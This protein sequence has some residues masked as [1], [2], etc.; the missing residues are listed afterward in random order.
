MRQGQTAL[1][2]AFIAALNFYFQPAVP[3]AS[4]LAKT[5]PIP[6][7]SRNT[8]QQASSMGC[9]SLVRGSF[10]PDFGAESEEQT[11]SQWTQEHRMK[12]AIAILPDPIHTR[13]ALEFDRLVEGIQE[14]AVESNY[15]FERADL[16]PWPATPT[17]A[18]RSGVEIS[19]TTTDI[20]DQ[21]KFEVAGQN[22]RSSCPG[23]LSFRGRDSQSETH[24]TI[25]LVGEKPTEGVDAPEFLN[26]LQIASDSTPQGDIIGI[27]GPNFS[28]SYASLDRL[29]TASNKAPTCD[30][31]HPNQ[32]FFVMKQFFFVV[33]SSS[34]MSGKEIN[35]FR[36]LN[37]CRASLISFVDT[38][39][40]QEFEIKK[41]LTTAGVKSKKIAELSEDETAFGSSDSK[42]DSKLDF[43]RIYFP[44]GIVTLRSAYQ[45]ASL[46]STTERNHAP[47]TTLKPD[48]GTEGEDGDT[49]HTYATRHAP[50]SQEAVLQEIVRTLREHGI[51]FVI[52]R[53]TDINDTLFLAGRLRDN[54]PSARII[55]LGA[56]LLERRD[57]DDNTLR[58]TLSVSNYPPLQGWVDH[59]SNH[60]KH[61]IFSDFT[62]EG[63]FN[64]AVEL[65]KEMENPADIVRK[66]SGPDYL[67]P[68]PYAGFM[69]PPLD[70]KQVDGNILRPRLWINVVGR[71]GYWPLTILPMGDLANFLTQEGESECK[72][73]AAGQ[74]VPV[75]C[76]PPAVYNSSD[77]KPD[78]STVK[79]PARKRAGM[80][81]DSI[82]NLIVILVLSIVSF[83]FIYSTWWGDISNTGFVPDQYLGPMS[84]HRRS[85]LFVF[86]TA[87]L[88]IVWS[89][90]L[91]NWIAGFPCIVI[92]AATFLNSY[93]LHGKPIL[94]SVVWMIGTTAAWIVLYQTL[95]PEDPVSHFL[96]VY[97]SNRFASGLSPNLPLLLICGAILW[98]TWY[99]LKTGSWFGVRRP[100]LPRRDA[101]W[102]LPTHERFGNAGS[103]RT[104]L[105]TRNFAVICFLFSAA[106]WVQPL[107]LHSLE[108]KG[109]DTLYNIAACFALI[110]LLNCLYAAWEY[111]RRCRDLLMALNR[112]PLRYSFMEIRGF[113]WQRVWSLSGAD[114]AFVYRPMSRARQALDRLYRGLDPRT[115]AYL[116]SANDSLLKEVAELT[117]QLDP[118]RKVIREAGIH[119]EIDPRPTENGPV[120]AL[121]LAVKAITTKILDKARARMSFNDACSRHMESFQRL[122]STLA[123]LVY[124]SVLENYWQSDPRWVTRDPKKNTGNE[125]QVDR[126]SAIAGPS[127]PQTVQWAEEFVALVYISFIIRVLIRIR[128]LVM[129]AV[130]IYVFLLLAVTLYPFEPKVT[131]HAF[132][133]SIFLAM[134]AVA[135]TIYAQ[136]HRDDILSYLTNTNPGELGGDY[137]WRMVSFAGVPLFTLLSAQIPQLNRVLFFWIKPLLDGIGRS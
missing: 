53:A 3:E 101:I 8:S 36:S 135:G 126:S 56:D 95:R 115:Q 72:I 45:E 35:G 50:L 58:G 111:W 124:N 92:A 52:I 97:R 85:M 83:V 79:D 103:A 18:D 129:T 59:S 74:E 105:F 94:K 110:L 1:L 120:S 132:F 112:T 16:M 41:F 137:W 128:W 62:Q 6:I 88:L 75:A 19:M 31:V 61:R 107:R 78:K 38:V 4:V 24:L 106:L 49:V 87:V 136:M 93:Y 39:A 33:R 64:A 42:S 127:V 12:F 80:D 121:R 91:P 48:L 113:E 86:A 2:L 15:N 71:D 51:A 40:Y 26:A 98:W 30:S 5:N 47:R 109:F 119:P 89:L 22:E 66:P 117:V 130:G 73:R 76:G 134:L 20:P 11:F 123:T 10:R 25:L 108:G 28:G 60:E 34:T 27:L 81:E 63:E 96:F 84:D 43:V 125:N 133:V 122:L 14:A 104:L 114:S 82:L 17:T 99:Q 29:I 7:Q 46:V 9:E 70:I 131:I 102:W 65:I 13:L 21:Y 100:L 67:P 23:I 57:T 54:Y 90:S 116:Q 32:F 118:V 69:A 37:Y 44:R 68:G 77:K 55:T